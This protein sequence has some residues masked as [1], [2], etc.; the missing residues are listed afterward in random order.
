MREIGCA[1]VMSERFPFAIRRERHD[2]L[3]APS[4]HRHEFIEL[5]YV[6][7]GAG[8]HQFDDGSYALVSGDIYVIPPGAAHAFAFDGQDA[9][10]II[11]VLFQPEF[12]PAALIPNVVP[13]DALDYF[14]VHP[15]LQAEER[16]RKVVH[17]VGGTDAYVRAVLDQMLTEWNQG[18]G[19]GQG[20]LRIQVL[21]LLLLLSWEYG[22]RADVP[23]PVTD[24]TARETVQ[25]VL[26]YLEM[27]GDQ[28]MRID[29]VADHFHLSRRQLERLVRQ[30]TGGTL[31][32]HIHRW[33]MGRARQLL[34]ES[35][36][37]VSRIA[38]RVGYD[39][40][41]SFSRLFLRQVGVSP[42]QY[43]RAQRER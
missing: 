35:N 4:W 27:H 7:S 20:L 39:D 29:A 34:S 13:T 1:E 26:G 17:L 3:H 41:A 9:V 19:T 25:R 15:F 12:L 10:S 36:E 30:E 28:K 8:C 24:S 43:R 40:P 38:E 32:D 22:I 16:T 6:E 5:V 21:E 2:A 23:G 11:N 18:Q 42:S 37:P 33:R 14:Y 31:L